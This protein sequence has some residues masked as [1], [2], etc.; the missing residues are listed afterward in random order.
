MLRMLE[1]ME[2]ALE[3]GT[4]N[5]RIKDLKSEYESMAKFYFF[6]WEEFE[7]S[8][9]IEEASLSRLYQHTKDKDTFAIIGSQD[10]DTKQ[11]R[12]AELKSLVG[13]AQRTYPNVGFN[14]LEGTYTYDNG[15]QGVENSLVVYNIPKNSALDIAN[16]I[17]Q[18]SII[19]KDSNYF[20]FLD[21]AGNELGNFINDE[22]NLTFDKSITDMFGSRL[23]NSNRAFA[24]ECKL[25]ELE[26]PGSNFSKQHQTRIREYPV[27][28]I[29][30]KLED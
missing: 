23:R 2:D 3:S 27:C 24:F 11:D 21:T 1:I 15:E 8:F 19:W 6:E 12:S 4:Y 9:K 17:N 18:E 20:G 30:T 29:E 10:Q 28:K 14:H 22:R 13:K 5:G 16:Q 26:N 7:E 25:L